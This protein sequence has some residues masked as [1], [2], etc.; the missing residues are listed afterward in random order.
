MALHSAMFESEGKGVV[1]LGSG[2]QRAGLTSR[3][4]SL[5]GQLTEGGSKSG[6]CRLGCR[7][8]IGHDR[9]VVRVAVEIMPSDGDFGSWLM[10][11]RKE[12]TELSR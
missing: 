7:T 2:L 10:P 5:F 4:L 11:T 3:L 6:V 12:Q 8:A 1:S 9:A